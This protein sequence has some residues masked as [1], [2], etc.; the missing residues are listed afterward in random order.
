MFILALVLLIACIAIHFVGKKI[1][2]EETGMKRV[3]NIAKY[4]LLA[5]T[6][7]I[8]FFNC[9]NIIP[10]GKTGVVATFG[11]IQDEEKS[12]GLTLIFP[13]QTLTLVNIQTQTMY[14][15]E[16]AEHGGVS[17][18]VLSKDGLEI[19]IDQ[20]ILFKVFDKDASEILKELGVNYHNI[21]ISFQRSI[22]RDESVKYT[23]IELYSTKREEYQS[24]IFNLMKKAL[25]E[26]NIELEQVLIRGI[27]LPASVKN[28]IE[29]KINA[30]QSSQK[31]AFVLEKERQEADRK[32]IEAAGIRD[33][34]KI[35]TEH[36]NNFT[37]QLKTL[38]T[39]DHLKD[40]PNTKFIFFG[41]KEGQPFMFQ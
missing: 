23:A 22:T 21:I 31:M 3:F 40:S 30:E 1:D 27:G 26:R 14:T 8:L 2:S 34:Q 39:I 5:I 35:I 9:F 16:D 33:Y 18:N 7:L 4:L 20:S 28:A 10:S 15:G 11:K 24:N 12:P 38:E 41:N 25:A 37:I 19:S 13:W 6:L 17:M 36:A 32:R 29:E